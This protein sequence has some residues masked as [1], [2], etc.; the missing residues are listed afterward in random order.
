MLS[1]VSL[2][3]HTFTGH[4]SDPVFSWGRGEISV[5]RVLNLSRVVKVKQKAKALM[6]GNMRDN[7]HVHLMCLKAAFYF[8]RHNLP[9]R[10]GKTYI[11]WFLIHGGWS[12]SLL[13][14]CRFG[15]W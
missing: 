7:L 5:C 2:P 13:L 12:A 3:N 8:T 15:W 10:C 4:A 1:V 14:V 9:F 11:A 6:S